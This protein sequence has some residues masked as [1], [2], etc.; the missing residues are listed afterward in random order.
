MRALPRRPAPRIDQ[1]NVLNVKMYVVGA[2]NSFFFQG[3]KMVK[4]GQNSLAEFRH[5]VAVAFRHWAAGDRRLAGPL[6]QVNNSC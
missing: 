1:R 5:P 6:W 3:S 2:E 4:I